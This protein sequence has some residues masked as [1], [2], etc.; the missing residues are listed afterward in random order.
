M[1]ESNQTADQSKN[2]TERTFSG[3]SWAILG[4]GT[5]VV[6]K[7]GVLAVLARLVSPKEFGLMG[8]ATMVVEF[9]KMFSHMGIG[10]AIVQRE[11]LENR[12]LITGF[13]LSLSMGIFFGGILFAIAPTLSI[14]FR[15]PELTNVLRV[16]SLVFLIDSLTLIAQALMQRNMKFKISTAIE[17]ISYFVGYGLVGILLAYMGWGVWAL[18]VANL[19]Q[20]ALFT[21]LMVLFQAFP[22][23]LGF[24]ISAF[25]ELIFFGGGMTLAKIGNYLATQG[26]NFVV[27][28]TLGAGA[29]GIYGRAYQFMVMPASLFGNALDKAL[30]P[31]MSKVQNDKQRLAKAYLAGVS[32]I[33]LVSIPISLM[34]LFLAHEIVM[35]LL[36][37]AWSDVILPLQILSLSL[38]FRMSYKMSD[39]L[40]RATGAVYHRAWRQLIYASLVLTGSYIGQFWG[41]YGVA[42]GVALALIANFLMMAHLSL[43][44]T[45]ITWSEMIKA[46]QYGII[47][48][49]ITAMATYA[50]VTL[51]RINNL[52]DFLT[53]VIT[54]VGSMIPLI[55]IML[56]FPRLIIS[57]SLK[58]L[59]DTLILKRFKK[60]LPKNV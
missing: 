17:V 35:V 26:D 42:G 30:F 40:A 9:S 51:C 2:L 39:S 33:A 38:L 1:K 20:A 29:L 12:H 21:V 6:L 24:E 23:K 8:I 49:A 45:G 59:L 55:I 34:I 31:A 5:Q 22:K 57:D 4:S 10:P 50:I 54:L 36:G 53:L 43:R 28:R 15:M 11:K 27:G 19:S 56:F 18:V 41:L 25:K 32:I 44:I 14:F 13:T 48:G 16:I 3:F 52:P 46:H 47:S 58:E 37:A 7:I 60:L